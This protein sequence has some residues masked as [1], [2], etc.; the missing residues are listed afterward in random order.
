MH[1]PEAQAAA[2][3][4]P[5][6]E[7]WRRLR[8]AYRACNRATHHVLG[9]TIKLA[10]LVYFLFTIVFLVLRYAI[11]PNIDYYKGNIERIASRALGSDV[12]ITRIYASWR[13]LRPNLFLGDV[14]LRDPAGRQV[15]S[16]PSVSATLSWWSVPTLEPRFY[17]LE[18]IRPDLDIRRDASGQ[19]FVAGMPIKQGDSG[20]SGG[21]DWAFKQRQIL[22]REGRVQWTDQLRGAPVLALENVDVVLKNRWQHHRFGLRAT[23]PASL[24]GPLDVRADFAHPRF[25]ARMADMRQWKGE[26][27]ADLPDTDLA[28]WTPYLDYPVKLSQGQGSVRAWLSLD[29]AKL[30]GFTADVALAGVSA[31]LARDLPALALARVR[32]RLSARETFAAGTNRG[33]PAWGAHGHEVTLTDFS[34]LTADGLSLAPTTLSE[35]Y[36]PARGQTPQQVTVSARQLDLETL[37]RLAA[38]LPLS[39]VQRQLLVD[40]GLR[41]KVS[42]L[43][44]KWQGKFPDIASY[45][46]RARLDGLSMR[47]Q[48]ARLAVAKT[49]STPARAAFPPIPGIENLSGTIDASEKGG[50]LT[51]AS[52]Q[53]VLQL[54]AWFADPAMPFDQFDAR[55]RWTFAPQNKLLVELESLNFAQGTLTGS[56]SGTHQMTLGSQPGKAA[57]MVDLSGTVSGFALN[58]IGRYLP[59]KTPEHLHHWLTGALED[60]MAQDAT[61]RLRGDMAHF[62]FRSNTPGERKG[63]F[64][65]GGRLENARLNYA[66]GHFAPDGVAPVWPQAEQINGSFL[67]ERTRMEIKGDTARTRGVALSA[68]KAVIA[69]LA[70]PDKVLEIDGNAAAPMQDFLGYVEASPVLNWIGRFT[71]HTRATGNARLGLKLQL[72]LAHLIESKVQGSLQ[73]MNND[74][75]LFEPL[76]PLQSA[77][78][79]L[80]FNEKGLNLNGVGASFLGG[81]LAL[82]GGTQRDNAIVIKLAGSASADGIRKTYPAAALQ[83]VLGLVSGAARYTGSVVVRDHQAQVTVDSTLAGMGVELPAPLNK[84]AADSLPLHFTLTG[85]PVSEAGVARDEIR[86]ALGAHIGARYQRIK[87]GKGPWKVESGGIGVNVPAPIPDSGLMINAEMKTINVD[88]WIAIGS[89][90]AHAAPEPA[91]AAAAAAAPAAGAPALG[92]AEGG[93]DLAQ[94]VVADVL[95]ARAN[96][97]IISERKLDNVVVGASHVKGTWQANVD[98]RQVAGHVTWVE[99]PSGQGLGKVTA[100]LASLIIPES[101]AA[102]VKDLL[103][104]G[105]SAAATIPALDIVA[106]HFE[107]FNKKLGRLELVASN[108]QLASGREWQINSLLLANPDGVLRSTGKWVTGEGQSNTSLNFVLDIEDAGKLLDRFGFPETLR[109]GKG[110]MSGEIAWNGLPYSLD[111]PSLSGKIDMS[112]AAGQFLKQ[113]PGAAK[114]LG[115][116]SLQ[117]LPRLLKLDFHDV[118]SEGL[119]FDGISAN[120]SITRGV[121]RTDNLKM[122]GVAATVLMAGTADIANES[123]NLHVVVIPEFNLGT[124]PLVYA[125][126]VNPVVGLGSF[127]AQ[128]F[129]RAPVMKALTYEMQV[130]GPWKAPVI[131]KLGAPKGPPPLVLPASNVKP[132]SN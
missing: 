10:L 16:L 131:T 41:G 87:L 104:G 98:A 39:E 123:T 33:T 48:P 100:R 32:G 83:H 117:M 96:E 17:S 14:I 120:A 106:E 70:D 110:K 25:T 129:L 46:V 107:L 78:G 84:A 2:E 111:I 65:I 125:L 69:D 27:Y 54:P 4:L 113:D 82:T 68:V 60:G 37:S 102:G 19:L 86:L 13:G 73:L 58:S 130:T 89:S 12:T 95:A 5:I 8:S 36:T 51:L 38:Q 7:R 50:A 75:V 52:Q 42:D 35:S 132:D 55:A 15:L 112:V 31:Q 67:F 30:A 124:G 1:T 122:H 61:F 34:L 99:G 81:P 3:H 47:A 59:L 45:H 24:A 77:I 127:L 18:I 56:L 91:A 62:P 118:F 22:I 6:A 76:P 23:P 121:A 66:P 40:S 97:L 26:L 114:L 93:M 63:E 29:R 94:Y 53:L 79:K 85:L 64:R 119:A 80:E 90:V 72:P 108:A 103:E 116:L 43:S 101:A 11:L 57:D 71:E 21:A 74:V 20:D 109:R 88:Q 92:A 105:K 44:A 9:F 126:A 28:A 49:A 115:V 128:L